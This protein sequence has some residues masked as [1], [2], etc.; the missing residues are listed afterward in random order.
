MQ[1]T[2]KACKIVAK[3]QLSTR[4]I[5]RIWDSWYVMVNRVYKAHCSHAVSWQNMPV[6]GYTGTYTKPF[7]SMDVQRLF[8]HDTSR[9]LGSLSSTFG[10]SF[11]LP[12][13]KYDPKSRRGTEFGGLS[14]HHPTKL[15]LS[16]I[17]SKAISWSLSQWSAKVFLIIFPGCPCEKAMSVVK[18]LIICD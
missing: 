6:P 8:T 3:L 15:P 2:S 4:I 12:S 17:F 7:T 1:R 16:L 5:T 10:G 18:L 9:R 13:L 11:T 14:N